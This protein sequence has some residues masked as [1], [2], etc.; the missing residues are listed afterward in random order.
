M[1]C[2]ETERELSVELVILEG[3]TRHGKNRV[4]QHGERWRLVRR[5]PSGMLLESVGCECPTCQKLDMQDWRWISEFGD[6]NF[7][8]V[9]TETDGS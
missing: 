5:G 4:R 3:K 1:I 7:K 2:I 6:L 9:R 8:I